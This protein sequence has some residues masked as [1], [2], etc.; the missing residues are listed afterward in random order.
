M[1][2]TKHW[3]GSDRLHEHV[4][5]LNEDGWKE[6]TN[7]LDKPA[8]SFFKRFE[9]KTR[10][11]LNS[12]KWGMQVQILVYPASGCYEIKLAGE[13]RDGTWVELHKWSLPEKIKEGIAL[14]PRLLNAW[15]CMAQNT[16]TTPS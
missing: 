6:W 4:S 13:L 10:C 11:H 8:L 14:I 3:V 16:H 2:D 9:T 1:S 15:E 5:Q 7:R 12:D